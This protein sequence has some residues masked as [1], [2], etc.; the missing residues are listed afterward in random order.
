MKRI[1]AYSI[2]LVLLLSCNAL[3]AQD[4]IP[5]PRNI[6]IGFDL[7]GPIYY[8]YDRNNQS[9]EGWLSVDIDTGRSVV[10]EAG[11]LDYLYS[12][13]NYDY[14]NK[15]V[16]IR[17][18]MDFN[19]LKPE[20]AIGKYYAGIGLR[21]GLS[22]FRSQVPYLKYSNYWGTVSSSVPQKTY[23][24]HF[25]EVT[26]GIRTELFRHVEIGWSVRLRFLVYSSTG[27]DLKA[28]YIPGFGNGT[29]VVSP[30]INY[31]IVFSIPYKK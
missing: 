31:Y 23:S 1:Y 20:T 6:K 22:I 19:L 2:S 16:F 30:G 11:H 29:K 28:V 17:A 13:Y 8:S 15:G 14:K 27:K 12:Q 7:Y 3:L 26:P 10:I 4:S 21:Y 24:A 5:A 9:I 25:L 18:G